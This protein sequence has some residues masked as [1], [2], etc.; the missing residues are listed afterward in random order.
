MIEVDLDICNTGVGLIIPANTEVSYTR[1]AGGYSCKRPS[2][3]GAFI[4]SD[5]SHLSDQLTEIFTS[6]PLNGW[7]TGKGELDGSVADV[8][9]NCLEENSHPEI[10]SDREKLDVSMESWM[11]VRFNGISCILTWENSD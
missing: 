6:P 8:I 5:C 9:D 11:W 1:Q 2:L 3:T 7:C 10:K 4:P